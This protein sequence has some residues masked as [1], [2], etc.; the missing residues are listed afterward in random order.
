MGE[1]RKSTKHPPTSILFTPSSIDTHHYDASRQC[2]RPWNTIRSVAMAAAVCLTLI[3]KPGCLRMEDGG[4]WSVRG[5]QES[6]RARRFPPFPTSR[7]HTHYRTH[8]HDPYSSVD[9]RS[10]VWTCPFCMNRWVVVAEGLGGKGAT[11]VGQEDCV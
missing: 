10:K 8:K 5:H 11:E 1:A 9:F 6:W 7:A 2:L 4:T 3:G